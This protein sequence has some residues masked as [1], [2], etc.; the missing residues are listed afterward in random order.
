MSDFFLKTFREVVD[1]R[2]KNSVRRNDAMQLLIDL[3]NKGQI[4]DVDNSNNKEA[5]L[6]K[7]KCRV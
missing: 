4:D 6:V 2:E 3:M 5:E 1:Y 7:S